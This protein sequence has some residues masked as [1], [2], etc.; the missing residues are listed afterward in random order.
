MA[1][2][3]DFSSHH[4][5]LTPASIVLFLLSSPPL[6]LLF[7]PM[8]TTKTL[9]SALRRAPREVVAEK[10]VQATPTCELA[11]T[12]VYHRHTRARTHA[13]HQHTRAHT[14]TYQQHPRV[15]AHVPMRCAPAGE[16]KRASTPKGNGDKNA[17]PAEEETDEMPTR[18][19]PF[20]RWSWTSTCLRAVRRRSFT[21]FPTPCPSARP[22]GSVP[23]RGAPTRSRF[24]PMDT[25]L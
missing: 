10:M 14:Q 23:S 24:L 4:T 1:R 2:P 19:S 8:F 25:L 20:G 3:M 6:R 7:G 16:S 22:C 21:A 18:I 12:H 15:R 5:R 9:F 13:Y 11:R 17:H